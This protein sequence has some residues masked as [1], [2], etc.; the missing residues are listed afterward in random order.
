MMRHLC[1]IS[2]KIQVRNDFHKDHYKNLEALDDEGPAFHFFT[3]VQTTCN[4]QTMMIWMCHI[5]LTFDQKNNQA[6]DMMKP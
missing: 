6:V 4:A 1:H 3:S 5:L 2:E